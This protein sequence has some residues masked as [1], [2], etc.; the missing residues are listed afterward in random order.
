MATYQLPCPQC[1]SVLEVSPRHAGQSRECEDC[2]SP[3][4]I[5]KLGQLRQLPLADGYVE[6]RT[7]HSPSRAKSWLFS[8]G[9]LIA[10]LFG[11]GGFALHSYAKTLYSDIGTAAE[12]YAQ[13]TGESL[14]SAPP[15]DLY[16]WW[17]K[18]SGTDLGEWKEHP[19][20]GYNVQSKI[21]T[22]IAY[23]MYTLAGLGLL[24]MFSSLLLVSKQ[25]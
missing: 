9:L 3:I 18:T 16:E 6:K 2:N 12:Q 25:T 8:G 15:A 14:K 24:S 4:D 5:P 1:D 21:L 23:G 17:T 11:L 10:S 13:F 7:R 19:G 22:N 20:V